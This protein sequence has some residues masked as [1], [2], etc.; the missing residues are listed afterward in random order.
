LKYKLTSGTTNFFE[1]PALDTKIFPTFLELSEL[2]QT[3]HPRTEDDNQHLWP[4]KEGPA[5]KFFFLN[6]V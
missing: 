5:G 3:H 6:P 4:T 1:L 2:V